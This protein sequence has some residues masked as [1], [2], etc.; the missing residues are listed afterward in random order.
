[1]AQH[2][3]ICLLFQE[4]R[5]QFLAP[6]DLSQASVTAGPGA[7]MPSSGLCCTLMLTTHRQHAGITP[8]Y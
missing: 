8:T 2:L 7:P 4:T 6:T 5:V 1:M 3:R